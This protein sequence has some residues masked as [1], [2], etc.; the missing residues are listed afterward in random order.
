MM[1]QQHDEQDRCKRLIDVSAQK[2][3]KT[4]HQGFAAEV[5]LKDS[6]S[7]LVPIRGSPKYCKTMRNEIFARSEQLSPFHVFWTLSCGELS[8]PEV[9]ASMLSSQG[10]DVTYNP[11]EKAC[12][13]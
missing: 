1:A 11:S 13:A 9:P 3:V 2:G 8:W 10:M 7:F 4:G 6:H 5:P 12:K